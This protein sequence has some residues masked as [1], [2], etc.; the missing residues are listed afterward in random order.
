M[1]VVRSPQ[2]HARITSLDIEEA[3]RSPGVVAV[4]TAQDLPEGARE[5]T[6]FLPPDMAARAR[7]VLVA[8]EV[9]T[10]GDAIAIV[11]A[12]REYQAWDGA[13][14][15]FADLEP[16]PAAGTLEV[17][18][19][20]GAPRVYLD[21]ESNLARSKTWEFGDCDAA[22][23]DAPVVVKQQLSAARIC[24]AAMEPRATTA[25]RDGDQLTVW[26]STQGVFN[27]RGEISKLLGIPDGQIRVVAEDVGG[28]FGPKGTVYPEEILVAL[29]AWEL[30]RPVRWVAGRS[31]DTATTVH[32]HGTIIELEL[33]AEIDGRLRGVRGRINHDVGAYATSGV[34]QPN[35]IVPH[36]LSAYVVPAFRVEADTWFT[37]SAPTGFVRGG[38]RPLGNYGMER[39]MDRL[40]RRLD[41]DPAEL[42][43]RN[44]IRPEQMPYDTSMPAGRKTTVYDSGDYPRLLQTALDTIGY[45]QLRRDQIVNPGRMLG[46]GVACCVEEAGFGR[47]EPARVRIEKDGR[48]HL[49]VGSTPQGQ[50]HA[51]MAAIVL[52]DRLGWP[53]GQIEV[54]V[55][56]TDGT[57]FANFTAGSRSAIHVGNAT[58]QAGTAIR[59]KLLE[60]AGE[61]LEADP[62]DLALE[63]GIISVRGVPGKAIPV[64]DAIPAEGLEV[65]EQWDAPRPTAYSS[66]CHAALVEVDPDT[67]G[68][69]LLRY[70]IAYDTGQ[71]INQLTL[72]GQMQGGWVHGLG[73]ALF[74]EAIYQPDGGFVS[75]SFLDYTI[76]S[77]PEAAT[78][79]ELVSLG[80]ATESN[81]EGTK[82]A[83]ES[84]T[85]PVPACI[86][87]AVED[88]IRRLKPNAVV[89][90]IPITPQR[91]HELIST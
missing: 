7:P 75:T 63:D 4:W 60:A 91:L 65:L 28:G 1:A 21:L 64:T 49:F 72:E 46:I 42:R 9:R 17:A 76:A 36:I 18:M 89:D 88:A 22:F 31:E 81:P 77:A 62:T 54:T 29:A 69:N 23:D 25:V 74:E 32:A 13:A 66:S 40:A 90:R 26:S 47:G 59:R 39:L 86:S 43:R 12:E 50:G 83:G 78:P 5:M 16:L 70:V 68:V 87:N 80:A 38:G 79:L 57:P 35:N 2:A 15:V 58:G 67:G 6:D 48:A 82:G 14:A 51:T 61:V 30:G 85:I 24:G 34:S 73:Y 71:A 8:S 33:A 52:A 53:L 44:L 56:D 10:I 20:E 55:A 3:R 84:G 19:A 45:D 41:I 11:I 37:N 27:V